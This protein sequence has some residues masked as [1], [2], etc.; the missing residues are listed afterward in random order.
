MLML[1]RNGPAGASGVVQQRWGVQVVIGSPSSGR[2]V[3]YTVALL[4]AGT[5]LMRVGAVYS[6]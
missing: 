2:S 3:A 5:L 6:R 1:M 4:I